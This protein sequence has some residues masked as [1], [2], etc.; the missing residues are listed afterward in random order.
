[1]PRHVPLDHDVHE[2]EVRLVLE[3]QFNGFLTVVGCGDHVVTQLAEA[4]LNVFANDA[5]VL[6]HQ[7][8]D[9]HAFVLQM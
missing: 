3:G 1:M 8:V 7:N 5:L 9:G 2:R 6:R 4:A